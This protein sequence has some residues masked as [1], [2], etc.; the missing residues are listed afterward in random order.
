MRN[1]GLIKGIKSAMGIFR[2][3]RKARRTERENT[4]V[5]IPVL[6]GGGF[7][8]TVEGCTLAN[9]E[10]EI[11][12]I[13]AS[14]FGALPYETQHRLMFTPENGEFIKRANFWKELFSP[15]MTG[16]QCRKAMIRIIHW[17]IHIKHLNIW[18]DQQPRA[19]E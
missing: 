17:Y 10:N 7:L 19:I 8:D 6:R 14:V 9:C 12:E 4:M 13:A 15:V 18:A 3:M 16:R 5:E 1:I 2:D 11:F